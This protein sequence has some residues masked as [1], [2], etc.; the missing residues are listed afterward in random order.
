MQPGR[1]R[2]I[3]NT[4]IAPNPDFI[5]GCRLSF[6]GETRSLERDGGVLSAMFECSRSSGQRVVLTTPKPLSPMEV[7]G[8]PDTRPLALAV[9]M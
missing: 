9:A 1:I 3:I 2:F 6:R 7:A 5:A 8:R 4:V